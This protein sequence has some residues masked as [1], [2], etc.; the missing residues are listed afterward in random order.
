MVLGSI[1]IFLL[2]I[3]SWFGALV[4]ASNPPIAQ[5]GGSKFS[6]ER[7]FRLFFDSVSNFAPDGRKA[8]R[9]V[10][11]DS[12]LTKARKESEAH[13]HKQTGRGAIL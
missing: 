8:A 6:P 5:S 11:I 4:D 9:S 10:Y 7:L 13:W 3:L 2:S 12:E 1:D